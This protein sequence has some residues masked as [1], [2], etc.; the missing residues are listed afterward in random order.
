MRVSAAAL[1]SFVSLSVLCSPLAYG[2]GSAGSGAGQVVVEPGPPRRAAAPKSVEQAPSQRFS[3]SAA[4]AVSLGG[5]DES[6]RDLPSPRR[7]VARVGIERTVSA[8]VLAQGSWQATGDGGSVWRLA[9]QSVNAV[10]L[11]VHFTNFVIQDGQVWVHDTAGKQNFGPYTGRGHFMDANVWS[12]AVY[13]DTVEIEY[14]PSGSQ[15]SGAVPFTVQL[16]H[17]YKAGG[18][19]APRLAAATQA[20]SAFL[21]GSPAAASLPQAVTTQQSDIP[22]CLLDAVC[23]IDNP[24]YPAVALVDGAMAYL[25]FSDSSGNGF[26]CSGQ[27]LNAPNGSPILLTAGHCINDSAALESLSA[28]FGF[29][30]TT[31][32]GDAPNASALPQISGE[33]LLSFQDQAFIDDS[34]QSAMNGDIDY[35]LV[36]MSGFPDSP[37][38]TLAGYSTAEIPFGTNVTSVSYPGGYPLRFA[39]APRVDSTSLAIDPYSSSYFTNAYEIAYTTPGRTDDGSSGSGI[40]DNEGHLLGSLSTGVVDCNNPDSSGN[41]PANSNACD[42][43]E[44]AYDTWYE[45]FGPVYAMVNGYL[46]NPIQ[47]PASTSPSVFS[48]SPNP[49]TSPTGLGTV[50]LT[51]KAPSGVTSTEIRVGSPSGA[52][53]AEGGASGTAVASGWVRNG[54]QFFLQ[55]TTNGDALTSANTLA[56]V[57]VT[58]ITG[59][60]AGPGSTNASVFSANP[61]PIYSATGL[62]STTLTYNAGSGVTATQ[63]HVGSPTGPLFTEGGS[64]GS[65]TAPGWVSNGLQFYLQNTS[66]GNA[67]TAANTLAVVTMTVTSTVA[68]TLTA[69]PSTIVTPNGEPYGQTTLTWSAPNSQTVD[70]F[71]GSPTGSLFASGGS[72][73]SAPTGDWVTDGMTFYLVDVASGS[74]IASTTVH[75]NLS[76]GSTIG[77]GTVSLY[78][79]PNPITVAP[80]QTGATAT[81]YWNSGGASPVQIHVGSAQGP[82]MAEAGAIGSATASGWVTSGMQFFLVNANNTVLASTTAQLTTN[83]IN[84]GGTTFTITNNPIVAPSGSGT[85]TLTWSTGVSSN[86]EIHEGSPSGA[87]VGSGGSTGAAQVSGVTNGTVFYLQDVSYASNANGTANNVN[88][89]TLQYTL[90]TV[91]AQVVN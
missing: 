28:A 78:L 68:G 58:V 36:L 54:M 62:G 30:D 71:V 49:V 64:S 16:M 67:L 55:D 20:A 45:K 14:K 39:Y 1:S 25:L 22:S 65:A 46:E 73:G 18:L 24:T 56:I 32:N 5:I 41:C 77:P 79:D 87:L 43:T 40:F 61:N 66:N 75:V 70:I 31:C 13:S 37:N 59:P 52:L 82:L 4:P 12:G 89:L 83:A 8:Q 10:G 9:L 84:L 74:L 53:L 57:S 33:Q 76:G 80:G 81:V 7:G 17:L 85:A 91:T 11:R 42:V 72:S 6:V 38:F 27:M 2:R 63:I 23:Y 88:P 60:S 90:A 50:T 44:F 47:P 34:T 21:P 69:S 29:Q 3:L 86:V 35:S 26:Q 15:R 19:V 51:F 48:A